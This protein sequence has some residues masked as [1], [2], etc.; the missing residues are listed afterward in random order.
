MVALGS[1]QILFAVKGEEIEGVV[2]RFGK[3]I[4]PGWIGFELAQAIGAGE[5]NGAD[6]I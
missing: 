1:R 5:G 2:E 3:A 4:E 6:Q